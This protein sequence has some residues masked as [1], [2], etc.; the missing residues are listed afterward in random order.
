MDS[1]QDHLNSIKD[2]LNRRLL[3]EGEAGSI[4]ESE[5][6]DLTS[7]CSNLYES[8]DSGGFKQLYHIFDFL[9]RYRQSRENFLPILCHLQSY[10]IN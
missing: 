7:S 8:G 9:T 4:F 10:K 1:N 3:T 6:D 5:E 2:E